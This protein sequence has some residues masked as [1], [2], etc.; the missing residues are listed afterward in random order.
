VWI[1]RT[2]ESHKNCS[3]DRWDRAEE[4]GMLTWEEVHAGARRWG[5]PICAMAAAYVSVLTW[6]VPA[7]PAGQ[8]GAKAGSGQLGGLSV[9]VAGPLAQR[10]HSA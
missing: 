1:G 2:S 10:P 6:M 4:G 8:E 5:T 7:K 9:H 3:G